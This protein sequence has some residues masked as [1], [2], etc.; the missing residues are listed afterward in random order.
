M[1]NVQISLFLLLS[2]T[3]SSVSKKKELNLY[4]FKIGLQFYC[5]I[6]SVSKCFADSTTGDDSDSTVCYSDSDDE[7]MFLSD[8]SVSDGDDE[9]VQVIKGII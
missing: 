6:F 1:I 3:V 9:D 8:H 7:P 2:Y 4:N 5:F